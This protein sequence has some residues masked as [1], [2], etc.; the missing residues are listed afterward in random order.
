MGRRIGLLGG[1]FDPPHVGHLVVAECAR[2]ALR[3]DEVRFLVAGQPWMK[4][5]VTDVGHRLAMVEAAVAD[6][7]HFR[8]DDRETRRS[9]PTYTVDTLEE[10][11]QQESDA[12][13]WFLVGADAAASLPDWD[14]VDRALRLATFVEVTRPGHRPVG[15]SSVNPLEVPLLEISSTDLRARYASGAAT[16]YLTSPAVDDYVRNHGLYGARA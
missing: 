15:G 14:R 13:Y 5:V 8:I 4:S 10:L 7:P 2:V 16:R 11:H 6:D 12:A 1:T 3:L 9:G